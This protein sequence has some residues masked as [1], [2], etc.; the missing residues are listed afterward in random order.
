MSMILQLLCGLL[1]CLVLYILGSDQLLL[2]ITF[3]CRLKEAHS[4]INLTYHHC[5]IYVKK[6]IFWG[7]II[8]YHCRILIYYDHLLKKAPKHYCIDFGLFYFSELDNEN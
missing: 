1:A 5:I 7:L 3:L 2:H 4:S 8:C 6:D